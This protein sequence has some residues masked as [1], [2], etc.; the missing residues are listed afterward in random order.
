MKKLLLYGLMPFIFIFGLS[1]NGK[2]QLL[3][4]ENFSYGVG[5]LLTAN[6]WTAHSG[7][8]T[9]A[10][11]TTAASI[12]YTGYLSSGI[13][14]EVS[15]VASGED[16]NKGFTPQTTGSFYSSF[17]VNVTSTSA[18]GDYFFH[19]GPSALGTAFKARVFVK[20]DGGTN[21]AFGITHTGGSSNP[22]VYTAFNYALNTTYLI[23]VKYTFVDGTAND[24]VSLII[25]P[26]IGGT[27]PTATVTA[28]DPSQSDPV[29]MGTVALRQGTT[30]N[31]VNVKLDGIRV[32]STWGDVTGGTATTSLT[33]G[34]PSA[35]AQW[36]QGTTYN[37]TWSASLTNPNVMIEFTDNASAG[38]PT[39]TTLNPS[40]AASAGTWAWSIPAGQALSS[41]CK[42]RITDIPVTATGLSG[43]FSIVPPP[44]Q[45][46]TLAE[47]RAVAPGTEYTYVGQ[48]ILTFQQS[49]RKQKYI[50]DAT[51][52]ILIDDN[53]GKITTTYNIGD[54]ITN[55]SGTVAV[56]NGMT[57]FTPVS[58][59]GPAA[60]TG[61]SITPEAV[62]LAQLS[63][64]WENYEAE[65]IKV[66]N[67]TFTNPSG[68][69][70]N[71]LIYPVTDNAGTGR[72]F[73][74]TFFDVD[75][76]GTPVPTVTQD[77]VVIPNSRIDGDHITS[78][79]LADMVYNSGNTIMITE[80]MY[81]PIDGG[82]DTIEFIELYNSGSVSVNMKDW[83]FSEGVTYVFPDISI[84]PN[85]Y[86]VIARD[87]V[88]M[89]NTF[90]I[91]CAQWTEG[92]LD[93]AGE[94][95]VLKDAIGQVKDNVYFLP[96]APWPTTPNN[97][98]PS[99]TFCNTTL[100]NSLGENW[101]ASSNQVAVNGLGE[102]IYASPG[103]SCST[104]ANLVI[105][106]IMFNPPESG[107]DS[108]E[109]I[110]IY[111]LGNSMNLEGFYFSAGVVFEF[112]SVTLANGEYTLVAVNS[113][114]IQN[115]FGK[116][117]LQWTSGGLSNSGE[118][119]TLKD[120][121]GVTIDE[122]TYAN[123]APWYPAANGEGPSLT[124]CDPS[125]NNALPVNWKASS[126]Y[127]AI[128]AAGDS[129]FA[130]PLGGCVNPPTV[131]N[132]EA[133]PTSLLEGESVQFTDLSTNNPTA[134]EWSFIGGAPDAS[135]EQ[136]P[137]IQYN[138]YGVYSVTLKATNEFGNST[139]TKT[140]YI[141]VGVDGIINLPSV[142]AVYPNPTNGKL[143]ITNPSDQ[144][145]EITVFNTIGKQ[146]NST[147]S[148]ESVISM[149]ITGQS[150]GVYI[151]KITNKMKQNVKVQKV[152]LK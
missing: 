113:A 132:F 21:L 100:D 46:A 3:F 139:I 64:N 88:S 81:N 84:A 41:D 43:I 59:P 78:R 90:G 27:E 19:L 72:D 58:D 77:L 129:I 33:V 109:F 75:Y 66:P 94:P 121:Y 5:S 8:G 128:N 114:A 107:S 53:A 68:N 51:A 134:W 116:P 140:D 92:F 91:T 18:T 40:I 7:A 9:N 36:R 86:Y 93:D 124:L 146:V 10:V 71:G 57:Q 28:A 104:G 44:A 63:A 145:L 111:N 149:D 24:I 12:S 1:M 2:G 26:V 120:K 55:I 118:V 127:A 23:V 125:S 142:V 4:E 29:D 38:T 79:N 97:G 105:T 119:I 6:G 99:L 16:V 83:Y 52:A 37:I 152:V 65:I 61:N 96:V 123:A 138:A 148:D 141:S 133:N 30:A 76:I 25:N 89:Q 17:L 80:I 103:S 15:L 47:L 110:E 137:L 126:E 143:F 54:A 31:T 13:G 131:A 98:G 62:T 69:F 112:P 60:S 49:F 150:K 135:T 14:D 144:S 11:S 82:N 85:S 45:I 87:A 106:E 102:A 48:G 151:V 42:I 147:T 130:T 136:N 117:S 115:T 20:N 22:P 34:S 73:R 67:V 56:F 70:A 35:G 101:S 32:G 39:W 122:V 95:I 108:L 50:Q 74:T